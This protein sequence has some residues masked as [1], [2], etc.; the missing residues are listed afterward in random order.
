MNENKTKMQ[1]VYLI[2]DILFKAGTPVGLACLFFLKSQF[3]TKA[4]FAAAMAVV[5]VRL[6][7]IDTT[8]MVMVEQNHVNDRQQEEIR[9]HEHRIRTL[10]M[11]R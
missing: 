8:L 10:E 9:D 7:K 5:D 11:K 3:V 2:V 1:R 6:N 4:E